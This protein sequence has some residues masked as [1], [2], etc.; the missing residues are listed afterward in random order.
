[1]GPDVFFDGSRFDP[2]EAETLA[3]H[4]AH[5]PLSAALGA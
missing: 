1:M 5:A 2:A 4:Y 3:D